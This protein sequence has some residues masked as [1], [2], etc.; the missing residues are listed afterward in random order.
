MTARARSDEKVQ[1]ILDAAVRLLAERGYPA[2]TIAEIATE[3]GV[4]RGLLHYYFKSKE[5]LLA[6][7]VRAGSGAYMEL[8]EAMFGQSQSADDLAKGLVGAVRAILESDPTFVNLSME[9]WSLAHESPLVARELEDLYRQFRDAICEGLEE[10]VGRGIIEP[11]IPLDAL[12]ALLL[13]ITDGVVM[14]F[15]IHPALAA[16]ETLWEGLQMA[17]RT[18]LGADV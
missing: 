8:V 5:Q 15:L 12:A 9:C 17:A 1:A 16:D 10:A 6:Q 3:A 4:S 18:L 11:A 14:Q 2:T 7:V 13:A